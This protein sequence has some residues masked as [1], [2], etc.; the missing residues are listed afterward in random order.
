MSLLAQAS[1]C[2]A[3]A[4]KARADDVEECFSRFNGDV[5]VCNS[6]YGTGGS[7]NMA[8]WTVCI[9]QASGWLSQCVGMAEGRYKRAMQLCDFVDGELNQPSP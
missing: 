9:Q 3:N 1:Q 4:E 6:T 8:E 2:R 5:Q 7:I